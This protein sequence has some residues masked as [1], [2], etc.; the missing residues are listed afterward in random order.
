MRLLPTTR[1]RDAE[2]PS[3]VDPQPCDPQ[4][5]APQPLKRL[6]RLWG[7]LVRIMAALR[8]WA[9]AGVLLAVLLTAFMSYLSLQSAQ[10]A[11]EDSNWVAH[12]EAVQKTLKSAIANEEDSV[13][14]G[15]SF[16]L[17]G[18]E[19]FLEIDERAHNRL[20]RDLDT[21]RKLV[22][23]NP[24]QEKRLRLLEA[25]GSASTES[26]LKIEAERQRSGTVPADVQFIE[27][28]RDMDAVRA[29]IEE[30]QDEEAA[31]L[32][33]RSAAEQAAKQRTNFTACF[34]VLIGLTLVALARLLLRHEIKRSARL[35][36]QLRTLSADLERRSA[37]SRRAEEEA[38]KSDLRLLGAAE[39][40]MDSLYVCEA[41][42]G[43]NGE[44]EDFVLTYVNTNA[45]N[46][47]TLPRDQLIGSRLCEIFPVNRKFG[48][49][50]RYKDVVATGEP[51]SWEFPVE[52]GSIKISWLRVQAVK[53]GD[54]MAITASDV[55][56]RKQ[57]EEA[58]LKS[59]ILLERTELLT[60]T[61][62]WEYDL[63]TG[64]LFWSTEMRRIHGVSPDYR[65]TFDE[66]I[67]FYLPEDRPAILA[68]IEAAKADGA[69]WD[70]EATIVRVD[71]A[72][73]PVRVIGRAEFADGVA[74][75]LTGAL[76][77]IT[78]RVVERMALQSARD[79]LSLAADGGG[80]GIWDWDIPNNRLAWDAWMHRLYGMDPQGGEVSYEAWRQR[81][82]PEDVAAAEQGLREA[83]SGTGPFHLEFRIVWDNGTVR[84]IKATGVVT[85]DESSGR[86]VR[87][88]GTSSDITAQKESELELAKLAESMHSII[89]SS[90][91]A[92]IVTDLQ[93]V[94]TSV[95]PAAERMLWYRK[96]DLIHRETPLILLSPQEVAKR[97]VQLSEESHSRVEPGIEV[98]TANPRRGLVE[99]AEWELI[100]R[101]GSRVETQLTV[102]A[103]T[104]ASGGS[105]GYILIAYDITERKRAQEF[106]VHMANH[107]AL[108]GLPTRSLFRDRLDVALAHALRYERKVA[109]LMVDLDHFKRV[110]DLMGHHVG[111]ELLAEVANR[112]KQCVR[113]S[114]TVARMGGDEFTI[115]L[116]ELGC[117]EDAEMVAEKIMRELAEPVSI[118]SHRLSPTASIGISVYPDNSQTAETLLI[119]ADAAMYEAKAEGRN[120]RQ[121]FTRELESVSLRRR[122]VEDG[123]GYALALN[124]LE[125]AYQPQICLETGMVTGVEAL[126]RWRSG[127]LGPVGPNEFI[128][129]AEE[130]GIIVPLGEWVLRTACREGKQLQRQ[131]GR[132]LTIA[133][134]ISPRQFQQSN[135]PQVID[136][137]LAECELDPASLELEITENILI[138]DMPKP[139]AILEEIRSLGVRVSID[140]FGT[141]FSSMSYILRF[142][143]NRLKIDQSFIREMTLDEHSYAVTK[144]V[145]GLAKGLHIDVV[146]EGVETAVQRD[147]LLQEGCEEAQGYFYSKPVPMETI[148]EV[149]AAIESSNSRMAASDPAA[150]PDYSG[151]AWL[152]QAAS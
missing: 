100:R 53:L 28:K 26:T 78:S 2:E 151:G 144:A 108:T 116:D 61:G 97:A 71:G 22:A 85:R 81:L 42:R 92:T 80:I 122:Q 118:G 30:M 55:T 102:S 139:I 152:Q 29:T 115:L 43:A 117:V 93:G 25:Q 46:L 77:D 60:E 90:P 136:K 79:R 38:R 94:I 67:R 17:T 98:L 137:I 10:R 59:Q 119:N 110:N 1:R 54:G 111:D 113:A 74:A 68:V 18:Q 9:M 50:E 82:H 15:H 8:V 63:S 83:M 95:N 51:F 134:N 37:A 145:I 62:G 146:A 69:G 107:D 21:L 126:L 132:E 32:H 65:P 40:S 41:L 143:V 6:P 91:F 142:R 130:T 36:E 12:I 140:D 24:A 86:A 105:G 20:E 101:D 23:D 11:V 3:L 89:A 52:D 35:R 84:H 33:Q 39:S 114:D 49:F 44:I 56:E 112:L 106:I 129:I 48:L 16:A 64:E 72:R 14:G 123:L 45:V 127:K 47:V 13:A 149:I 104:D 147:M 66:A 70:V 135:L 87:I 131:L 121:T 150:L 75:R 76:K 57:Q 58:L 73:V 128:S 4:Q 99:E 124:E 7:K 88:V 27:S 109:V 5:P 148:V 138:G 133:V 103:L 96:E 34:S 19:T 120:G 141:G 125:L 31:L